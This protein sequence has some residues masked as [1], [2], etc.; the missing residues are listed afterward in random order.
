MS[1][2]TFKHQV[3]WSDRSPHSPTHWGQLPEAV[4]LPDGERVPLDDAT[5]YAAETR[6]AHERDYGSRTTYA[7]VHDNVR[8]RESHWGDDGSRRMGQAGS[9][10]E[11]LAPK[12]STFLFARRCPW[13]GDVS[14]EQTLPGERYDEKAEPLYHSGCKAEMDTEEAAIEAAYLA[15][16]AAAEAEQR[17]LQEE[18]EATEAEIE[19][20]Y[21]AAQVAARV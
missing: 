10:L 19:A 11:V 6:L 18:W 20:G 4:V 2:F 16:E 8:V 17:R 15:A 1:K 13:C 5:L 9:K 21:L 12:G 14:G 3:E 7:Q